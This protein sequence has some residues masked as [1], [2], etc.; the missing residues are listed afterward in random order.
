MKDF[1]VPCERCGDYIHPQNVDERKM[2][3]AKASNGMIVSFLPETQTLYAYYCRPKFISPNR[4]LPF[5]AGDYLEDGKVLMLPLDNSHTMQT[6]D[7]ADYARAVK[8][9]IGDCGFW[10]DPAEKPED[11]ALNPG[12]RCTYR[13][14]ESVARVAPKESAP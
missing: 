7:F 1:T 10:L 9:Q 5:D 11:D 13:P 4:R 8:G 12:P 2:V 14:P 6:I 3:Q